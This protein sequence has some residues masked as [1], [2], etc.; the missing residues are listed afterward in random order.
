MYRDK[1]TEDRKETVVIN[2]CSVK[3][4]PGEDYQTAGNLAYGET[5][6]LAGSYNGWFLVKTE[7]NGEFWIDGKNIVDYDYA[8]KGKSYGVVTADTVGLGQI[9]L[10]EGNLV[11]I[12]KKDSDRSYVRPV[13][14]D[15]NGGYSGWIKNTDY[16]TEKT[17]VYFNQ[18]FLKDEA[19]VYQEANEKAET[20]R[21]FCQLS[22]GYVCIDSVNSDGWMHVSAWGGIG[23]WI[24]NTDIFLP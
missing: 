4:G 2:S 6:L 11:W 1:I 13:V 7:P 3:S 12:L 17:N 16:T 14:I 8:R 20:C 18:A 22:D 5:V 23:G 10:Q 15:S 9:H 24:K 19:I 21:G